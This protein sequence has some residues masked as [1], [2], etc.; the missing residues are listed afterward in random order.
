MGLHY[1]GQ[2][3]WF[4]PDAAPTAR[5]VETTVAGEAAR[6]AIDAVLPEL[7][8]DLGLDKVTVRW[9]RPETVE[10][11]AY[12]ETNGRTPWHTFKGDDGLRG[13]CLGSAPEEI[14]VRADLSALDAAETLGHELKHSKHFNDYISGAA[15]L[16]DAADGEAAAL[17]YGHSVRQALLD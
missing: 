8:K 13:Q 1:L 15:E 5:F 2:Q 6:V 4:T 17:A 7:R 11:K 14:W 3:L 16:P 12:R 9:F 10:R